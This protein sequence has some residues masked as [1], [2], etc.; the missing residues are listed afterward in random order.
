MN[1]R[2]AAS[3]A[4]RLIATIALGV[5]VAL[6]TT[7][8]TFITHQ[9]TTNAYSPSDGVSIDTTG[10]DVVVRNA[11]VIADEDGTVGNF[12][13]AF[14][15]EGDSATTVDIDV[16]GVQKNLR[17]S[18]GELLSLGAGGND[19]LRIDGLDAKPG[20]TVSVLITAGDGDA[21][22]AQ[23]PVLDGTLEEYADLVP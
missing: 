9:A 18:A 17:V 19:P 21:E 1:S 12:V 5:A 14:V 11:F 4:P 6:G 22:P 10:G 23:V 8:C 15:N 20:T 13:A 3:I 7:G 16:N 2:S